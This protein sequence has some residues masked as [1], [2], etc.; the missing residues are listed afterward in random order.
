MLGVSAP[1]VRTVVN[2]SRWAGS[3]VNTGAE[4]PE[5]RRELTLLDRREDTDCRLTRRPR[6]ESLVRLFIE[7]F[8]V[9]VAM[10]IEE[11]VAVD[12]E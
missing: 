6:P 7:G 12:R 11:G 4:L 10:G 5:D 1:N 9:W 8:G 2:C 3:I